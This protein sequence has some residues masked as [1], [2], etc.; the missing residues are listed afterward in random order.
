MRALTIGS[1][2]ID[3]IVLVDSRN[4]ERMTM[5]NENASFL[6]LE[7]GAKVEAHE[8]SSHCGG[9]AVN[10]SVALKRLGADVSALAKTGRDGN[11]GRVREFL[12]AQ[13]VGTG[14]LLDTDE[15]ATGQAVMVSS[16]DRNA[17]IFTHRGA[18]GLIRPSDLPASLFK[19]LDFVYVSGLSNRSSDC[20]PGL[21][22]AAI[23][24]GAFVASNP[25]IR[26]ITSRTDALLSSLSGLGLMSVNRKEANAL[27][28]AMS[29]RAAGRK[30]RKA[31]GAKEKDVPRLLR[32]GLSF[33][34]FD[35]GLVE[36][37]DTLMATTGLKRLVITDG[38]EGA[39]LADAKGLHHCPVLKVEVRG[40]AGAG[41]A[42]SSTLAFM[43]ASGA[44]PQ[45]ALRAASINAASVVTHADTTEG[46]LDLG[47]LKA[48]ASDARQELPVGAWPW[49]V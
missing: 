26:Q 43:L 20:F 23:G 4:V 39:M 24:S 9:G 21:M 2:M 35:M 25:G 34:G 45:D 11:A 46:L 22:K 1:A 5:T 29:A 19:G 41:D 47:T 15:L 36:F 6:L 17:T 38:A 49:K 18:N 27:V 8:I 16:H 40:T 44:E 30:A 32:I 33:G 37:V 42:F 10:T 14:R 3:I 48:R 7:Q 12:E 13:G 28:P 31:R